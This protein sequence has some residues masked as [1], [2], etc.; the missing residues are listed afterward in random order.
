MKVYT[1]TLMDA[2]GNRDPES[3][4][5]VVGAFNKLEDAQELFHAL[6]DEALGARDAEF[7]AV[8]NEFGVWTYTDKDPN[9]D[10]NPGLIFTLMHGGQG[11]SGLLFGMDDE[12]L[13]SCQIEEVELK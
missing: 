6:F 4:H 9:P 12:F 11:Q 1:V 3:A 7:E 5:C 8:E 2:D 13:W 10:H